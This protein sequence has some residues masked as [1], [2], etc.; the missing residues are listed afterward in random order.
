MLKNVFSVFGI[1]FIC[2]VVS[3]CASQPRMSNGKKTPILTLEQAKTKSS[4]KLLVP[5][6]LPVGF[7][8][9]YAV[10]GDNVEPSEE[11]LQPKSEAVELA[12]NG[13]IIEEQQ[14]VMGHLKRLNPVKKIIIRNSAAEYYNDE[15]QFGPTL[16]WEKDNVVCE[17]YTHNRNSISN[18]EGL[19][20]IAESLE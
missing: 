20:K 17:I 4:F 13:F 1:F 18:E 11:V 5:K 14:G 6:Q 12:Y 3:A 8:F 9:K 15:K 2:L 16:L 10:V 19:I 7:S